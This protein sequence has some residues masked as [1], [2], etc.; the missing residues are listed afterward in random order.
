LQEWKNAAGTTLASMS[1]A[2][3]LSVAGLALNGNPIAAVNAI[4]YIANFSLQLNPATHTAAIAGGASVR[5]NP[6]Y[7]VGGTGVANTDLLVNRTETSLGT[8]PGTQLLLDLQVGGSSKFRVDTSGSIV[9]V[10]TTPASAAATGAAGAIAWDANYI[11]VCT[12]ANTWKRVAIAT[13]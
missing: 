10:L 6:T 12:A 1:S 2:G 7:N 4:S 9:G 8:S 3:A 11:Y 13:W 5:V